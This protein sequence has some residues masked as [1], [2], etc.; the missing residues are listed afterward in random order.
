MTKVDK[1]FKNNTVTDNKNFPNGNC[2]VWGCPLHGSLSSAVNSPY[3]CRFH[4]GVRLEHQA[5]I[6]LQIKH[7]MSLINILDICIRPDISFGNNIAYAESEVRGY[8]VRKNLSELYLE[9]NLYKT[10]Q[11]ILQFLHHKIKPIIKEVT[12]DG[13]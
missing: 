7:Y 8:L 10:S 6:T 2:E 3:Y 5:D 13:Q 12:H 9:G 4:F 1:Y 11:N